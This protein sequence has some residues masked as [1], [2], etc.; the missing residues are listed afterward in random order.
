MI[1]NEAQIKNLISSNSL[2]LTPFK[3]S[4]IFETGIKLHIDPKVKKIQSTLIDMK[5]LQEVEFEEFLLPEDG[6][7]L[8]PEEYLQGFTLEHITTPKNVWGLLDTRGSYAKHGLKLLF[9]YH[10]DP[11]TDMKLTIH[12]KNFSNSKIKIYPDEYCMRMTLFFV[13]DAQILGTL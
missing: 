2:Q 11:S 8:G 13:G 9:D 5:S 3:D 4:Q 6:Y 12:I 1:L 10:V 7:I